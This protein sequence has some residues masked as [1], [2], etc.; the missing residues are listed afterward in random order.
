[1]QEPRRIDTSRMN[2]GIVA[3]GTY[4]PPFHLDTGRRRVIVRGGDEDATT[5]A[6]EAGLRCLAGVP[7]PARI[8]ELHL[9]VGRPELV[10]GP[11]AEVVREALGLAPDVP[12]RTSAGD[13][14]AGLSAVLAAADGV[15]AGRLRTV[16]VIAAEPG[17]GSAVHAGAVAVLVA[18]AAA[19]GSDDNPDDGVLLL[20]EPRSA[21]DTGYG[22]WTAADGVRHVADLRY[23][24]H[25]MLELA[26][27]ALAGSAQ[28][29]VVTGPAAVTVAGR[30][31]AE[32]ALALPDYGVAGPLL[33]LLAAGT[34]GDDDRAGDDDGAGGVG[35]DDP[36]LLAAAPGRAVALRIRVGRGAPG[37]TPIPRKGSRPPLE[38]EFSPPLSLPGSSP[39][40]RRGAAELL[41]LTGARCVGCRRVA[42]PPSQRPICSSCQGSEFVPHALART[43]RVYSYVVN[44]FLPS[45]F[46][47]EMALVLAELDDGARYWAPTSGIPIPELAIGAPVRLRLRRFTGHGG[48]PVYA[49]KFVG[50]NVPETEEAAR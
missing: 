36:V 23:L 8:D 16:L 12:T 37:W 33:G 29:S 27:R 38:P 34:I 5:L 43:G 42:Y 26:G 47:A 2:T 21:G 41:R 45:G 15:A 20:G 49:M 6:V 31:G 3:E 11:Q 19:P 40:F 25:R 1:M 13:A 9:A 46:G 50:A 24:E 4:L 18:P 35:P 22:T 30:L 44:R 17:D 14:L 48:A 39:F 32:G 10:D 28:A 7:G